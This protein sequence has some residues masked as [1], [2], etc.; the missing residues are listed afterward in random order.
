VTE[1][2]CAFKE[3]LVLNAKTAITGP[4]SSAE[5]ELA[6]EAGEAL[7]TITLDWRATSAGGCTNT[8]S[9]AYP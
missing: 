9:K 8:K 1:P 3:P 6:P 7:T 5:L 4:P 2:N